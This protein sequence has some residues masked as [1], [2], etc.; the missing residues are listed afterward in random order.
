MK[1]FK[2]LQLIVLNSNLWGKPA[3]SRYVSNYS[4][5]WTQKFIIATG[6]LKRQRCF[7]KKLLPLT[8]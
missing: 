5:L 6:I 1:N 2:P 4:L 3:I 7:M 8:M